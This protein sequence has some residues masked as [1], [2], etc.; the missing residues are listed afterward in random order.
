MNTQVVKQKYYQN[1][2]GD[3]FCIDIMPLNAESWTEEV[4]TGWQEISK[5]KA[6]ELSNPPKSAEQLAQE[7]RAADHPLNIRS[8]VE[9]L[10]LQYVALF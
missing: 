4:K 10:L 3:V 9:K 1:E 2:A 7:K 8:G 5:K 6:L